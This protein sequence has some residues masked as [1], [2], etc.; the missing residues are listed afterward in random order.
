MDK[1]KKLEIEREINDS[2]VIIATTGG[3]LLFLG[4]SRLF[5]IGIDYIIISQILVGI[6]MIINRFILKR[7]I[8]K[9]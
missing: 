6:F 8:N 7:R 3:F 4:I 9:K 1:K 5:G 2:E